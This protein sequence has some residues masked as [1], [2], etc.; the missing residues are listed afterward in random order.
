MSTATEPDQDGLRPEPAGTGTPYARATQQ[1]RSGRGA[2]LDA[3]DALEAAL[4]APAPSRELSWRSDVVDALDV[5]LAALV[6]QSESDLGPDSLL[7]EIGRDQPRLVPRIQ[8]LHEEHRDLRTQAASLRRQ[9][10]A[11]DGDTSADVDPAD[12]RDRL[13]DL[14]RRYRRHRSRESDLVYE[15]VTIDL[16]VGD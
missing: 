1:S 4:A 9:L 7:S 15:S 11:C 14:A 2:S 10:E 12:V 5:F 8:R 16:G 13:A 3:L 6:D